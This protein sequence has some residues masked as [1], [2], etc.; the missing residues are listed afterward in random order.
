VRSVG[1]RTDAAKEHIAREGY[2]RG[3]GARPPKRFLQ[4]ALEIP[5][6]RQLI[7]GDVTDHSRLTLGF[8]KGELVFETKVRKN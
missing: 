8:E 5:L 2:D 1:A 3:Y 4:R 7:S 6:S